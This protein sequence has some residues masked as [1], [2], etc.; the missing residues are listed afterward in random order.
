MF[1]FTKVHILHKC[2]IFYQTSSCNSTYHACYWL[3]AFF[4]FVRK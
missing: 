2:S 4:W 1:A 3:R